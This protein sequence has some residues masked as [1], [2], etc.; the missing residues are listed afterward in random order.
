MLTCGYIV[1]WQ[2][3]HPQ[4]AIHIRVGINGVCNA[5]EEADD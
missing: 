5:V 1:V 4:A 2:K 3:Q